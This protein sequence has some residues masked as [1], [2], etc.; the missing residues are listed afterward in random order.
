MTG[1]TGGIWV[2]DLR[3]YRACDF[4]NGR[5]APDYIRPWSVLMP[6]AARR[7]QIS[8]RRRLP[9]MQ[10]KKKSSGMFSGAYRRFVALRGTPREIALGFSL[11]LFVGMSPYMMCHTVTA[12]FVA[13][14]LKW[15]KIA[16][17]AGVFITNPVTAPFF[18]ALTY[19]VGAA[20]MPEASSRVALPT[21]FHRRC[22]D[23]IAQERT[24]Y[25]L[26]ID[27]RGHCDRCSRCNCRVCHGLPPDPDLSQ[28]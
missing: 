19:R 6:A 21:A 5:T 10:A 2:E 28:G 3:Y 18:Y 27:G 16:A 23:G 14:L 13:A 7:R 8:R 12:V 9:S 22:P 17:A 4:F 15:N 26:D 24:G 1:H 25:S 11:G 20:I